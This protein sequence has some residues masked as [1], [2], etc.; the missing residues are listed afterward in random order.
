VVWRSQL[1]A[2]AQAA[3]VLTWTTGVGMAMDEG[4]ALSQPDRASVTAPTEPPANPAALPGLPLIL[5]PGAIIMAGLLAR[6][7]RTPVDTRVSRRLLE[8]LH[9]STL[10][11]RA[12]LLRMPEP[13]PP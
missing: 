13:G 8:N 5:L 4:H 9:R 1:V 7:R 10:Q 11:R 3:V 2:T 6:R 12:A